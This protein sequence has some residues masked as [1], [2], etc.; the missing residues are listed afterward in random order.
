MFEDFLYSVNG[1]RTRIK[2]LTDGINNINKLK[3]EWDNNVTC[4]V[5]LEDALQCLL[6]GGD[7]SATKEVADIIEK[8][9]KE[10]LDVLKDYFSSVTAHVSEDKINKLN[11]YLQQNNIDE[12]DILGESEYE[13]FLK[14]RKKSKKD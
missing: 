13:K 12:K 8:K 5:H 3:K 14:K 6:V 11:I 9:L 7:I 10:E 1:L 4:K 2:A